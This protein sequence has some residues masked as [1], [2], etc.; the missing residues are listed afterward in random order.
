ML[1]LIRPLRA[2]VQTN[3]QVVQTTIL[4][5]YRPLFQ[6]LHRHA[7]K[8]AEEVQRAYVVSA[9]AYYETCFRR[10]ARSLGL[11]KVSI[12]ITLAGKPCRRLTVSASQARST[13]MRD[14]IGA[15]T[16]SDAAQTLLSGRL[17]GRTDPSTNGAELKTPAM[18]AEEKLDRL[19]FAKIDEE[20]VI[21]GFQAENKAFVRST[22][23][24][25]GYPGS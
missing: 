22:L 11:V 12:G 23:D 3:I 9:R 13:E 8:V 1:G 17:P 15:P 25:T 19:K 14:L 7:P 24:G 5:K 4:L 10:Y 16:I 20:P 6:F 2:S 21:L 18:K